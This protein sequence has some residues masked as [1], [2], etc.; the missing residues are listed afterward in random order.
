MENIVLIG[1]MGSGKT[2]V[3]K[4]LS[5]MLGIPVLDTDQLI[6]EQE[7]M[8]I[9]DIFAQKGQDYF[10]Q[11]E[12]NLLRELAFRTDRFVL[13]VGGGLPLRE[14]NRPLLRKVGTVYYLKASVQTLCGRLAGDTERP[15]LRGEGTLEE[16]ITKILS[17]RESKY[18]DAADIPVPTDG[19][20]VAEVAEK[21]YAQSLFTLGSSRL[22]R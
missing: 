5:Q 12:T 6:A 17:E 2:S 19:L 8:S 15:L 20:S 9:N 16:K 7:G 21:I 18:E 4:A 22:F 14:E 11:A 10:R 1:F 3:G 13:S